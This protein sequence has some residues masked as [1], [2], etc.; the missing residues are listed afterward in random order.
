MMMALVLFVYYETP[1]KPNKIIS[2]LW[3]DVAKTLLVNLV[4]VFLFYL[5]AGLR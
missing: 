2:P 1:Q 3:V 4:N 5:V